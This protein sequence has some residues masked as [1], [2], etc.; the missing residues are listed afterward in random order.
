MHPPFGEEALGPFGVS[1]RP[2]TS[3]ATRREAL[4]VGPVVAAA[5]L[6]VDPA[7]AE[8]F[9]ERFVV[10]EARGLRRALLREHKPD[11]VGLGVM[12]GEPAPPRSLI[13]HN[14]LL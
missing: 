12:L 13:A 4:S 10:A 6:A 5:G 1:P 8:C 9:L 3:A 2:G 11:A 7:V 14:Q